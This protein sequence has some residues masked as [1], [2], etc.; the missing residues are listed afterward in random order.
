MFY[1]KS[2]NKNRRNTCI[3]VLLQILSEFKVKKGNFFE[4]FQFK[5]EQLFSY[6]VSVAGWVKTNEL[7]CFLAQFSF[8]FYFPHFSSSFSIF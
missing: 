4:Y 5:R 2:L 7:Q 1:P 3:S 6:F 8:L